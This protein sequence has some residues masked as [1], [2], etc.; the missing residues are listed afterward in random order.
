MDSRHANLNPEIDPD[1]ARCRNFRGLYASTPA[2]LDSTDTAYSKFLLG[3]SLSAPVCLNA[4]KSVT[5]S[6]QN[7]PMSHSCVRATKNLSPF[8]SSRIMRVN[9]VRETGRQGLIR[10]EVFVTAPDQPLATFAVAD[11]YRVLPLILNSCD[12]KFL[13]HT[14]VSPRNFSSKMRKRQIERSVPRLTGRPPFV[15]NRLYLLAR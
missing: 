3:L 9:H 11:P 2:N 13:M 1:A 15:C 5:R 7:L 4:F 6:N 10:W 12:L 8:H 14:S